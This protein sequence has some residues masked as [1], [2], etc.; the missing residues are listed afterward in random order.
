MRVRSPFTFNGETV[1]VIPIRKAH[2][3]G[4]SMVYFRNADALMVGDF[5]RSAGYPN[6]D[7]VNGGTL[8]GMIAA[9]AEVVALAGPDTKII[10]GHG[11]Q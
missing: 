10:P 2:T 4:D 8:D 9:L 11:F 5:Y 1:D 6:L 3:D 7:R